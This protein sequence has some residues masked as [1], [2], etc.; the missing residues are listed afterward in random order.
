MSVGPRGRYPSPSL[1]PWWTRPSVGP[2]VGSWWGWFRGLLSF[3]CATDHSVSLQSLLPPSGR[4]SLP[5][6]LQDTRRTESEGLVLSFDL[7][8]DS[9][10]AGCG[11][12]EGPSLTAPFIHSFHACGL[13]MAE[14][15]GSGGQRGEHRPLGR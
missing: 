15:R 8:P 5:F 14:G 2:R 7:L 1:L 13:M 10:L 9:G 6:C 11:R 4:K 3:W 12:T